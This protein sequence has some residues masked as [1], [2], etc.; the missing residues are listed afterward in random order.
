MGFR[1]CPT[2][3]DPFETKVRETYRA[4]VVGAPRAGID[5][6]D[7]LA[8]QDDRVEPRGHLRHMFEGDPPGLPEV[9]RF[10]AAAM[11]GTRSSE[12]KASLGLDLT[13]KFLTALGLPVPGAKLDATLWD[14]AKSLT[15][16]VRDV[17]DNQV[18]IAELG[19]SIEGRLVADNAATSIFLTDPSQELLLITRTLTSPAFAVRATRSGGQSV[20]V[21]V[22]GIAD[23]IGSASAKV[24]WKQEKDDWVSFQGTVPVTFGF[25]VVPCVIDPGRRLKFGLTRKDLTFGTPVLAQGDVAARPAIAGDGRTGLLSFD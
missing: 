23:L 2:R 13:S 14:G 15:F 16:E 12:L 24:S 18:D 8:R 1:A 9:T 7:T 19:K 10:P 5:P 11:S 17:L 25:S 3:E 22:D 21:A 6:L 20:S 4:N